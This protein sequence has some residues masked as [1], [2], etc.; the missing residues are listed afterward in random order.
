MEKNLLIDTIKKSYT[1]IYLEGNAKEVSLLLQSIAE[2][3][4]NVFYIENYEVAPFNYKAYGEEEIMY[5]LYQ[6]F[7]Y[8]IAHSVTEKIMKDVTLDPFKTRLFLEHVKTDFALPEYINT[9]Q[10]L[11]YYFN[12]KFI[13]A[14][15]NLYHYVKEGDYEEVQP[16]DIDE[17]LKLVHLNFDY[18]ENF[19]LVFDH[20]NNLNDIT[21]Y[22]IRHLVEYS[23]EMPY[24]VTIH[25][26]YNAMS[27]YSGIDH[28]IACRNI[29]DY[30]EEGNTYLDNDIKITIDKNFIETTMKPVYRYLS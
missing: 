15:N 13:A 8:A 3:N 16:L 19:N 30:K 27:N 17:F 6:K 12:R 14:Y 5:L 26:K 29:N 9:I 4:S 20:K 25:D 23:L 11:K 2:D 18:Y 22:Y 10:D 28:S 1:N 24:K 7:S 21:M